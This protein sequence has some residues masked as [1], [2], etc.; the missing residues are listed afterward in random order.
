MGNTLN[1]RVARFIARYRTV[2]VESSL[3]KIGESIAYDEA[4]DPISFEEEI[5]L[6]REMRRAIKNW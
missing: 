5:T 1:E 6:L 4:Q 3:S 2:V